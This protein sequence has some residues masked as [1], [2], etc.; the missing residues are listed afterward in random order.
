MLLT[1]LRAALT[2]LRA[3]LTGLRAAVTALRRPT[4]VAGDR[5][6]HELLG[7]ASPH[8]PA[9]ECGLQVA[10]GTDRTSLRK[11]PPAGSRGA[12]DTD[13]TLRPATVNTAAGPGDGLLGMSA[14]GV[15]AIH[16]GRAV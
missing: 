6:A 16:R 7:D 15:G 11:T 10:P 4:P 2:R 9:A 12:A 3:A 14:G 13:S 5:G 1:G 8:L